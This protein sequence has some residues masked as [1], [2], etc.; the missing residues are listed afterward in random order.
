VNL[1]AERW[2][3]DLENFFI[4]ALGW[5]SDPRGEVMGSR[6]GI[7]AKTLKW[8][9]IGFQQI[10]V[11]IGE[12]ENSTQTMPNGIIGLTFKD[13]QSVRGRLAQYGVAYEDETDLALFSAASKF[14]SSALTLSSPTGVHFRIHE[15]DSPYAPDGAVEAG[16]VQPGGV[17][18]GLGMPYV[19][20]FCA[21][22]SVAGIGRFYFQTLGVPVE[23]L[24][25]ACRVLMQTGQFLFFRGTSETIPDYDGHHIAIYVGEM[26]NDTQDSFAKMYRSCKHHNMVWNNPRFPHLTY[27]SIE[28]ALGHG[29]FRVLDLK[30]PAT[31][32]VVYRL[33]HEIRSLNHPGFSCK[34]MLQASRR[35]RL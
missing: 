20:F 33:E 29:E 25:G 35:P 32:T 7:S 26:P 19:E 17:S 3:L 4:K 21:P 6:A 10:H 22:E 28:D 12:P 16:I 23:E 31:G 11:P 34:E 24:D 9:N 27:D 5:V 18:T 2:T 1:N 13:L 8:L 30:D 14:P 15:A